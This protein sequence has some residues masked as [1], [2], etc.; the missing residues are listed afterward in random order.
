MPR[1]AGS[2]PVP[3]TVI[4]SSAIVPRMLRTLPTIACFAAAVQIAGCQDEPGGGRLPLPRFEPREDG[5]TPPTAD[6]APP[7]ADAEPTPDAAPFDPPTELVLATYNVQNLFDLIDDPQTDEGE[8]TPSAGGWNAARLATRLDHL[9]RAFAEID[10]DVVAVNEVENEEVLRQLRDAVRAAG[11]P[12]Y[13]YLALAP[14]RDPRGID[15][16][17]LSRFPVVR[18][19]GRPINR[20]HECEGANG[21]QVLD[22]SRPEARPILQAELDLSGDGAADLVA[23][24]GHWKAKSGEAFPCHDEAHRLRAALQTRELVDELVAADPARPVVA[25]GDLNTHEFEPPL[26]DALAARLDLD[27]VQAAGDLYNAWG[28]A[29]VDPG[30]TTNSNQWN[31]ARNSSYNFRGDWTR[32]DHLLLSGNLRPDGGEAAWRFVPGSMESVHAPFLLDE[33]GRPAAWSFEA[34]SGYSDHLPIRLRLAVRE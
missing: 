22:G 3:P 14:S 6:G 29:G 23:L 20:R 34:G 31:D 16:A 25:L 21:R 13:P 27:E 17:L 32:L 8:F 30:R 24:V 5:G 4:A 19:F 9:G 15:V 1:V 18:A 33:R 7:L 11:G 28:D 26:R 10:A 12:H 2:S